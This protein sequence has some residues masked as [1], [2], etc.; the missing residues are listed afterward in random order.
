MFW[1]WYVRYLCR[2]TYRW[3]CKLYYF[4]V[5]SKS[6]YKICF[7][8]LIFSQ[9]KMSTQS[10]GVKT[11][12]VW[13]FKFLKLLT[14]WQYFKNVYNFH[15]HVNCIPWFNWK[16]KYNYITFVN[17]F[18]GIV[19]NADRTSNTIYL[20]SSIPPNILQ[21][22]NALAICNIPMLPSLLVN[23]SKNVEGTMPYLCKTDKFV[24]SKQIVQMSTYRTKSS[25]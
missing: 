24:G 11:H 18:L 16:Y 22:V 6:D 17:F 15:F 3:K 19:R 4:L 5:G 8:I 25:H 12:Y 20:L 9:A 1:N 14:Q 21:Y 13:K 23:Q 10:V 7:R 2:K